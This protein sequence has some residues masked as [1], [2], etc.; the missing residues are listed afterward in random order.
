MAQ[1]AAV[2][3]TLGQKNMCCPGI[4]VDIIFILGKSI[5]WIIGLAVIMKIQ[6]IF[7]LNVN[8]SSIM[9]P[10]SGTVAKVLTTKPDGL[11]EVL[12]SCNH[13]R[14]ATLQVPLTFTWALQQ[15]I[16]SLCSLKIY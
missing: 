3:P 6:I 7:L 4:S 15:Y 5:Q 9:A 14:A 13:R 12:R 11:G 1:I 8:I 10:A 2:H 16:Q